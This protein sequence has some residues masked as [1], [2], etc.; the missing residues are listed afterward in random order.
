MNEY[1]LET[2]GLVKSFPGV[3]AIDKVDLRVRKGEVH[4]LCGENGAGKSTLM[5]MLSGVYRPD[6][7]EIFVNGN[8]VCFQSARDAIDHKIGIV[9]QELSLVPKLSIAE[10][11][12]FNRQ[13]IKKSGLVDYKKLNKKAKK[14]LEL[15][16]LDCL[17]PK[18]PVEK[19]SLANQQVIEILKAISEDP[20]LIILDE[21]T[22]SLTETE[23]QRLFSN[24]R[25]LKARGISFIYIASSK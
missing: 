15:F 14:M 20:K 8:P 5:M 25:K 13:P 7:G 23:T 3:V 17:S 2:R 21:P 18:T 12:F 19:L 22:S 6:A 9:F 4:A 11:I 16:Q 24:I 1:I 10:N